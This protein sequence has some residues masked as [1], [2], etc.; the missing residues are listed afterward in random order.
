MSIKST[1]PYQDPEYARKVGKNNCIIT[2]LGMQDYQKTQH[3]MQYYT[4]NRTAEDPNQIWLVEHPPIY[5]KGKRSKESDILQTLPAP[6]LET[7]RG[8]EITYHGPGQLI[9]YF[10]ISLTQH[11]E[12]GL[13]NLVDKLEETLVE[14]LDFYGLNGYNDSKNRGI[15]LNQDKIASIGL[16]V[17]NHCSYHGFA[18]NVCMDLSPFRAIN[19]CGAQQNMTQMAK[20]ITNTQSLVPVC[21][22][23]ICKVFNMLSPFTIIPY[24]PFKE[25]HHEHYDPKISW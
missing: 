11:K 3:A 17:K 23:K 16:R 25:N 18:L 5:T 10:L 20:H 15:Y 14:T 24:S 4:Q 7:D 1:I 12:L 6:I 9:G 13:R 22:N 21:L 2:L 8:G 19:P